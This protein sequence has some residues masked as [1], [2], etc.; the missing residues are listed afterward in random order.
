MARLTDMPGGVL[1]PS[2]CVLSALAAN[3][4]AATTSSYTESTPR[5]GTP[6]PTDARNRLRAE[7]SNAQGQD[8][9]LRVIRAGMPGLDGC[10][11]AYKLQ[12][13]AST[14]WRGWNPPTW[15]EGWIPIEWTSSADNYARSDSVT[16][17]S[18]QVA[19]VVRRDD[20]G[21]VAASH[22]VDPDDWSVS[23]AGGTMDDASAWNWPA[24]TI[25]PDSER[26]LCAYGGTIYYSDDQG[27]TWSTYSAYPIADSTG[28]FRRTRMAYYRG[29]ILMLIEDNTSGTLHQY[30]SSDLGATFQLVETTA[31]FGVDVSIMPSPAG[32]FVVYRNTSDNFAYLRRI[33]SAFEPLSRVSGDEITVQSR[34][35]SD[36]IVGVSDPDGQLW[37]LC[38][39]TGDNI[40]LW[41]STDDGQT[42]TEAKG[43]PYDS[44]SSLDKLAVYSATSAAGRLLLF[45]GWT[46]DTA[47]SN[48]G[49]LSVALLGGWSNVTVGPPQSGTGWGYTE[50][51]GSAGRVSSPGVAD[52]PGQTWV[53]IELPQNGGGWSH[54]GTAGTLAATGMN[55][56]TSSGTSDH[57]RNLSASGGSHIVHWECTVNS[58]GDQTSTDVA[59]SGAVAD[60]TDDWS[61]QVRMD[62]AGF[63]VR[64]VTGTSDVATVAEDLTTP[65]QFLAQCSQNGALSVWYRRRGSTTWTAAV[66]DQALTSNTGTPSTQGEIRWGHL[67]STTSDSDWHF[68]HH[69]AY[70]VSSEPRVY[71]GISNILGRSFTSIPFPILDVSS[72]S[73]ACHLAAAAGPARRD[74]GLSVDAEH[75]YPVDAVFPEVSP[76]PDVRWRAQD[77]AEQIL[78]FDL[79]AQSWL[80]N[81][82]GLYVAKCNAPSVVLEYYDGAAWQAAGTLDLTTGLSGLTF[83]RTGDTIYP[84]GASSDAGRWLWEGELVDGVAKIGSDYRRIAANSAGGWTPTTTLRPEIRMDGITGSEAATGTVTISAPS[85]L[86]VVYL[87]ASQRR[88]YWRVRIPSTT[89]P[90]TYTEVGTIL[91]GRIQPW[92][93]RVD[94]TRSDEWAPNASLTRDEYGT[95]HARELGPVARTWTVSWQGGIDHTGLRSSVA[96]DYYGISGGLAL[97]GDDDVPLLVAGI[98]RETQSGRVPVVV[99]EELPASTSTITDPTRMLYGRI[100]GS[101]RMNGVAGDLGTDEIVRVEAVTVEEIV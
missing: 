94:W 21:T 71:T 28:T 63:R 23:S 91:V 73:K 34:V 37:V 65:M 85:G 77:S 2:R 33:A 5:P 62:T 52:I 87:T 74:D 79:G 100:T 22:T 72:S 48:I 89:T 7:V 78:C 69:S 41:S 86:L 59:M 83:D 82:V 3:T 61:W 76:S 27:T 53:P 13:D 4:G 10:S 30:A 80:G 75:D 67:I 92:G 97:A 12:S 50:R 56:S 11:L 39:S 88:R 9:D 51:L 57:S 20:T 29:N 68:V 96:P 66:T 98:L 64:D 14:E 44:G 49:G 25:L 26:L 24:V 84:D 16:I 47:T 54:S 60:G 42:W 40:F 6:V 95:L 101:V 93:A 38:R 31:G 45:H 99:V 19:V 1:I 43:L 35:A 46:V 81:A 70:S 55:L 8:L 90:E 32:L 58:G 15:M 17:P 18:T 36:E